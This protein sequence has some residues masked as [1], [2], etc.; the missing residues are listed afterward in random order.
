MTNVSGGGG[1]GS[2]LVKAKR[3]TIYTTKGSIRGKGQAT[4]NFNPD[5]TSTVT[6]GTFSLTKGKGAYKG[7]QFSGKFD[8]TYQDGVYTFDYKGLLRSAQITCSK[9][10][11]GC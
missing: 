6:D 5:G 11:P 9:R 10:A 4:Q 7:L 8:G 1:N 3:I 2:I